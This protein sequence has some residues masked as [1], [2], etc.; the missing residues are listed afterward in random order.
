[1]S[2]IKND[3][4]QN[5]RNKKVRTLIIALI[6]LFSIVGYGVYWSF[7]DIN[8][9]PEGDFLTEETSPDGKYTLR[10]YVANGGATTDFSIRGELIFNEKK[11]KTKNIYWNYKEDSVK[12]IW[13]DN[14][15]VVINGQR[16]NLPHEKFDW[17]KQ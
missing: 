3:S 9:L 6:L 16:L 13:E 10:A 11:N 8:R 5:K 14:D 7:Y 12:I 1:M 4:I 17:R 2:E 15:T